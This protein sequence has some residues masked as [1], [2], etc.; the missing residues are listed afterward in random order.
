[1]I[2]IS[3]YLKLTSAWKTLIV[4]PWLP[5]E[6]GISIAPVLPPNHWIFVVGMQSLERFHNDPGRFKY[7]VCLVGGFKPS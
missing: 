2:Y 4:A 3:I 1:M 5:I 7:I 6:Q